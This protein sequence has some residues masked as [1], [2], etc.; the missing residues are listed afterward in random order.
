M[1][2][3]RRVVVIGAST[4][5]RLSESGKEIECAKL[6]EEKWF[7]FVDVNAIEALNRLVKDPYERRESCR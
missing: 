2:P 1:A 3:E 7:K 4:K 6:G 5:F